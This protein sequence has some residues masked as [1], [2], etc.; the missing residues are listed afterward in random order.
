M[1]SQELALQILLYQHAK[2][3]F[4]RDTFV[5]LYNFHHG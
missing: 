5:L 1:V 3:A 4:H 2:L